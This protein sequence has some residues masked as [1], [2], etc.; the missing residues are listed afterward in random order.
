MKIIRIYPKTNFHTFLNS[1]TLWGNLVYA[2]RMLYG[3]DKTS[4]LLKKYFS[5][6]IPF[7]VSSIFPFTIENGEKEKITYYLPK[8]ITGVNIRNAKD[9]EEMTYLK[10]FKRIR[11]INKKLFE[12]Y[13]NGEIDDNILLERFLR[14]QKEEIKKESERN[15]DVIKDNRFD[16]K[17][18][19]S[20]SFILHNSID[21]MSGSTLQI[22]GKGQLYWEEEFN[23]F[24]NKLS[25]KQNVV[26]GIY[27]LADGSDVSL[28]EGPLRLLSHIGIGGNKSIGKG[29]FDFV[30]EDFSFSVPANPNALV[31]LSLFQPS[32]VEIDL[33]KN[34]SVH[35]FYDLTTRIGKV[36]KDFN[37]EFNEKNPVICFTEGSSFFVSQS[38]Y[39]RL[40]PTAKFNDEQNIYSNYLFFGMK[41]NLRMQ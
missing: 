41:A 29:S 6:E 8:P 40:V 3:V 24:G 16:Y 36:G 21:R 7:K 25:S 4:E 11:Y 34:N 35:L 12:G 39:G 23:G 20:P 28:I 14:W 33:I 22:D 5:T 32:Q 15:I 9:P 27:F 17:K 1:D 38:L 26:E 19:L 13:L 2:Y 30:I 31:S 37:L 10:D 18:S